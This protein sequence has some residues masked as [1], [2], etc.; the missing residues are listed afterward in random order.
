MAN[1]S[2]RYAVICV[3][4]AIC[5]L[6]AACGQTGSGRETETYD[7]SLTVN[8]SADGER[9]EVSPLVYGQFIEHIEDCIYDGIWSEKILDRKFYYPVGESGLSPWTSSGN[10]VSD[11]SVT[12]SGGYSVV[13]GAGGCISQDDL[14]LENKGYTGYFYCA[15]PSGCTVRITLRNGASVSVAEI[16]V[17]ANGGEFQKSEYTLSSGATTISSGEYT[18]EVLDGEG[19]F[20]SLSMMPED[21]YMG[22]RI[23]TLEKLKELNSPIYRWPGGNFVSGYDWRDGVGDRDR[24][25]SRRN[26]NYMGLESDFANEE[27][28]IASDMVKLHQLGFYG[29]IEPNDFG[30]HE[31]MAMCD[32]LGAEALMVVNAGLGSAEEA[33]ALVEYCNGSASTEYGAMR[34]ANG[35]SEPYAI[36]YWGVGNEMQGDWQL[37]HIPLTLYTAR[38]NAFVAAMKEKDSSI[39]IIA[40][41]DNASNWSDGMFAACGDSMDFIDEHMYAV[42]D[43]TDVFSHIN[44]MRTNLEY[45]IKNHRDLQ[46][47]YP[48]YADVRIAFNEYAYENATN[49]SRLKDGMGIAVFLNT[50]LDNADVFEMC[51]YSSTINATQGCITT[52]ADGAVMQGA[53]YVLTMYRKWMQEYNVVSAVR[54]AA[55]I[56]LDVCATVS[57]DGKTVAVAVVNPS[58]YDVLLDCALF[59]NASHIE[60]HTLT[61]DYYDSYN[62]TSREEMYMEEKDDLANAVAPA[63]SVS[64]FV[65][66]RG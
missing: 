9:K 49:P 20:D 22:M 46:A 66:N 4:L 42:Q 14:A 37:G 8:I 15:T 28:M 11:D 52:E 16:E 35:H 1:K 18:L 45:R 36:R 40:C 6:S 38:H 7:R 12:Y 26:L 34:A 55:D 58:E 65:V 13:I 33:A 17:P 10:V 64:V 23:D 47:K 30:L 25:P 44:N 51:C 3:A 50:V 31:F 43:N 19:R 53:G 21:N 29:G 2:G 59:E 61:G 56:Q 41:G 60:R 57:A 27:A 32:Y 39:R 5:M 54:Y 62:S 24:R 63:M 48:Q